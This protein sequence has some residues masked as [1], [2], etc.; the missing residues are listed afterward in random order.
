MSSWAKRRP[1]EFLGTDQNNRSCAAL[2]MSTDLRLSMATQTPARTN[3]LSYLTDQLNELR[4]QGTHFRLRVLDDEQAPVCTFD[5]KKVINLASNNYLGLTTHPKLREAAL[6]ATR[7]YGVGSGAVRT[8]AGT[9]KIHLELEEKIARFKNVEG[10]VVFQSGFAANAG[11]VSGVLG[12]DGFIISDALN[13]ASIIDGARLSKAKILVFRHKDVSHA[14]EQ[15]ASIKDEPG[16]KLLISDGVFSMD[17][18]IG[19]LPGLCDA[20][21]KYGAIMMVDDAHASGVLGRNGRGTIDHFKV[22]GRVDVQVGTL[23]KAIGALGGYVCGSRDLIDFLYHRA[24][25][26]LFSTSHPPSVAATCIAAFEVL[27]QEP[28]RIDKLWENTR[29]WKKELGNLGFNIGG[30]NTPASETPITPIIVGDGRL[31]M[32]F[33]RELFNEGVM[34]TGIAFPTVAEGKARLRTIMTATH[35]QDQLAKALEVLKKVG[36]RMGIV[37]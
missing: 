12:K 30:V 29:F 26:F 32:D 27:E 35:T 21:E 15:L 13:H 17:G 14:E 3:P 1:S 34:G 23:S 7:K 24:R 9:M 36:K 18:D 6:A 4:A 31:C 5:G 37:S 2:R 33:S 11:T 16:K 25:P 10:C 28:E 22:H 20:A 19:P 8:I